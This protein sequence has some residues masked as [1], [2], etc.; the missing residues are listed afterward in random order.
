ME[1]PRDM[2]TK[3]SKPRASASFYFPVGAK[4]QPKGFKSLEIEN[5]VIVT[6]KGKISSISSN[7][8]EIGDGSKDLSV[9]LTS[10]SIGEAGP[11]GSMAFTSDKD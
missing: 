6:V 8:Y 9:R 4:V 7:M 3:K 10:C 5:D 1:V 2:P 11:K